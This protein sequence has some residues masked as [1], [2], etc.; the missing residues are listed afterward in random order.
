MANNKKDQRNKK[1]DPASG[2]TTVVNITENVARRPRNRGN[3]SLVRNSPQ[4]R[5]S[6]AGLGYAA[7]LV[8]P[9]RSPWYNGAYPGGGLGLL[10]GVTVS[11]T[12]QMD[13]YANGGLDTQKG[14]V[15]LFCYH[16]TSLNAW[17]I[18]VAGTLSVPNIPG[19]TV[20]WNNQIMT[21]GAGLT[22]FISVRPVA[23]I[24]SARYMGSTETLGGLVTIGSVPV[25]GFTSTTTPD[26]L[27]EYM[28][29][30]DSTISAP[31]AFSLR[32]QPDRAGSHWISNAGAS[33]NTLPHREDAMNG[34]VIIFETAGTDATPIT[35]KI[36]VQT[37]YECIPVSTQK[38]VLPP[39]P[40]QPVE[41]VDE[42]VDAIPGAFWM[43]RNEA[44]E[45][46]V[47]SIADQWARV[48]ARGYRSHFKDNV[49]LIRA[50]QS[51]G[52]T[53]I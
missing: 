12:M 39:H 46:A 47:A 28:R 27:M 42:I 53:S 9:D 38:M 1:K 52:R 51:H 29:G 23:S 14:P 3:R 15:G 18:N 34:L 35:Y 43:T 44:E 4:R 5:L 37:V 16:P 40:I 24:I 26:S 36:T 8:D 25:T 7:M 19:S 6:A 11:H 41:S 30:L 20:P 21:P 17:Y 31:R 45:A 32:W 10:L 50:L 2:N 22:E 48:G 33:W 49:S 13:T